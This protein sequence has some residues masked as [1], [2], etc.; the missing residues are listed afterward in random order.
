MSSPSDAINAL[1]GDM[2]RVLSGQ[3]LHAAADAPITTPSA[4]DL[5]SLLVLV[6]AIAGSF[7][8]HTPNTIDAVSGVGLHGIDSGHRVTAPAASDLASVRTLLNDLETQ[9][10]QHASSVPAHFS[11]QELSAS[12]FEM[13]GSLAEVCAHANALTEQLNGHFLSALA[14]GVAA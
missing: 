11:R 5:P 14:S 7:G 1:R 9:L 2:F 12:Y 13:S 10:Q 4:T 6:N 8:T 3:A